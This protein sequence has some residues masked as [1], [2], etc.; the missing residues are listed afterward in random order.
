MKV[1]IRGSGTFL[2][3]DALLLALKKQA[4][5]E[6]CSYQDMDFAN[7]HVSLEEGPVPRR[8]CSPG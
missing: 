6:F 3:S 2:M 7:N 8:D 4:A 5:I 1:W